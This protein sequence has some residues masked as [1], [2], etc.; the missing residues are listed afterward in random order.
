MTALLEFRFFGHLLTLLFS[1][2]SLYFQNNVENNIPYLVII[3]SLFVFLIVY[4]RIVEKKKIPVQLFLLPVFVLTGGVGG[5]PAL[6]I[7]FLALPLTLQKSDDVSYIVFAATSFILM[8]CSGNISE[9]SDFIVYVLFVLATIGVWFFMRKG[10][11]FFM[12]DRPA[13]PLSM[14]PQ[15]SAPLVKDP[16]RPLKNYLIRTKNFDGRPVS[17]RLIELLPGGM[18]KIYDTGNEFVQKGLLF[19]AVHDKTDVAANALLDEMENIPMMPEYNLS[20][21]I[22]SAVSITICVV[23]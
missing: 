10:F 22:I 8:I 16:F 1:L 2:F 13:A 18:A 23:P 7:L 20:V 9:P 14:K 17:V 5:S 4:V 19:R 12:E 11:A 3:W 21:F 6:P 15:V